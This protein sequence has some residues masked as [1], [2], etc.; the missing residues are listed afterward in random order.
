[1]SHKNITVNQ[2]EDYDEDLKHIRPYFKLKAKRYGMSEKEIDDKITYDDKTK[3]V[4][5]EGMEVNYPYKNIDSKTYFKKENL[6]AAWDEYV[7]LSG[8]TVNPDQRYQ[9]NADYISGEYKKLNDSLDSDIFS[10]DYALS[11]Y[12]RYTDMGKKAASDLVSAS[13]ANNYGNVDTTALADAK[14]YELDFKNKAYEKVKDY[15]AEKIGN[16]LKILESFGNENQKGFDNIQTDKLNEIKIAKEKADITGE[17]PDEIKDNNPY[18]DP[19]TGNVYDVNMDYQEK[20]NDIKERL[21][22]VTDPEEKD[23][24][25]RIY[26]N[27]IDARYAK[28]TK[29]KE[30]LPY[31]SQGDLISE[32]KTLDNQKD[33]RDKDTQLK[34]AETEAKTEKYKSDNALASDTYAADKKAEA[35]MYSSDISLQSDKYKADK[36]SEADKYASLNKLKEKAIDGIMKHEEIEEKK[37]ERLSK[38]RE[39]ARERAEDE[40]YGLPVDPSSYRV[41]SGFGPRDTGIEGASTYHKSID[42]ACDYGE[43]VMSSNDGVVVFAGWVDGYGNT[44]EIKHKDNI[45][46]KYHHMAELPVVKAGDTV[47]KGQ[48]IGKVGSTGIS[49]GSHLDFQIF[50]DGEPVDPAKY[51][52]FV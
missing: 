46:T 43:N 18:I 31:I 3:K 50:V 45:V 33:I 16:S 48:T 20:I 22:S 5:I 41:S 26:N 1:M 25:I 32:Y 7:N 27:L 49:S 21:A 28:I 38:E 44:V 30:F 6:D 36:E 52:P 23:S 2:N 14:R 10:S 29:N 19:D 17:V 12:K 37:E 42:L 24:L 11:I 39:K 40:K 35:D 8:K 34:K 4:S 47:K 13:R 51:I 9:E 15:A